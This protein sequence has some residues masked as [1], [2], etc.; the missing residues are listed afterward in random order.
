MFGVVKKRIVSWKD[1]HD[2]RLDSDEEINEVIILKNQDQLRDWLFK[3]HT[4]TFRVFRM[5]EVKVT[6]V[7]SITPLNSDGTVVRGGPNDL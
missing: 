4:S 1:P 6:P 5:E 7:L 3:N 2:S